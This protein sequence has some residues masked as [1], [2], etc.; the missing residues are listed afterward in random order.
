MSYGGGGRRICTAFEGREWT[1]AEDLYIDGHRGDR[2]EQTASTLGR[3][4]AA[5]LARLFEIDTEG[6]RK[7]GGYPWS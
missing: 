1:L 2:V 4:R 6:K 7:K 3:T 5:V